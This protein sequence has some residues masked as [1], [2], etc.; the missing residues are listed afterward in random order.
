M[1]F[2]TRSVVVAV[3]VVVIHD[4]DVQK[5]L[6]VCSLINYDACDVDRWITFC[7][8][9]FFCTNEELKIREY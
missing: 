2:V 1:L 3:V 8:R 9:Q 7:C 6:L 5:A 4:S